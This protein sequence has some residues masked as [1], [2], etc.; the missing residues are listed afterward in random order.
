VQVETLRW[1]NY[2]NR[3]STGDVFTNLQD[4]PQRLRDS[5]SSGR[6]MLRAAKVPGQ[7]A[8][9]HNQEWRK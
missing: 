6:L 3:T 9:R 2:S 8:G 7:V 5:G 1:A 4:L